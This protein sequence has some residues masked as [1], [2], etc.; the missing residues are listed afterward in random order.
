MITKRFQNG[1]H[2]NDFKYVHNIVRKR[3][4]KKITSDCITQ[5]ILSD[6]IL[7]DNL[8]SSKYQERC[9]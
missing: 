1:E 6:E 7:L 8:G 3:I 2:V 4:K 9:S 5:I